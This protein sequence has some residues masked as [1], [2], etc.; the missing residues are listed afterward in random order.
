[1]T[2]PPTFNLWHAPW[3]TVEYPDGHTAELGIEQALRDAH[4]YRALDEPSPLVVVG[5]HRLLT[6]IAQAIVR[7]EHKSV[8]V[9]LWRAG[10]LPED[11]IAAFGDVYAHR[12]DLFSDRYPFLQSAD[13]PRDPAKRGRGKS[14]GY[15]LQEEPAGT[16]VAHY[17]HVFEHAQRLCSVCAARGLVTIP[18]F[19]SSGG[20]GIRPSINGVPPIYI[21]PGGNRFF[22]SLAASLLLPN[23][24]P[25]VRDLEHDT[26]W[27]EHTPVIDKKA[28]LLRVG[29]LHS[30]TFPARRIRLHPEPL[31]TP[32][33]RCGRQTEWGVAEM[34]YEQGES[35]P[36]DAPFW[37][38][39][40]A[41]YKL[42]KEKEPTPVRP[43][44]GRTLWREYGALLLPTTPGND[45]RTNLVPS[46]LLQFEKIPELQELY[47]YRDA[48]PLTAV[49]L[50]TDMK[51]KLFE[52]QRDG[53]L[54][55]P[56][57]LQDAERAA[58]V[59]RAIDFAGQC[60]GALRSTFRKHFGGSGKTKRYESLNSRMVQ[61]Y[62]QQ[63][64]DPFRIFV[65][66]LGQREPDPD[67]DFTYV[68]ACRERWRDLCF[69]QATAAFNRFAAFVG[70]DAATQRDRIAAEN[71]CRAVL[72]K[73]RNEHTLSSGE[74]NA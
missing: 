42:Q 52:W 64:A 24:R 15:L 28:E 62:W 16:G 72:Y 54:L 46:F 13:I 39:P 11:G 40:F 41:A 53:L 29:Y 37:R 12:F 45:G 4:L 51:M 43:V 44:E 50:R 30:L 25:E 60:A 67:A 70:N 23:F 47:P 1:M 7:P 74:D 63:L 57:L 71:H 19:A 65:L 38:D 35:R 10:R 61:F 17:R 34:V 21:L 2:G 31:Q 69:R 55:P 14:V 8:L 26:P 48:L 58:A 5:I 27:W 56:V 73:I 36:K 59:H 18:A 9:A 20:A 3:I 33:T 66:E 6:A 68:M 49:G 22:D 32:C